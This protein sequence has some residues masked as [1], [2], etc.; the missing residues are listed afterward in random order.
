[1]EMQWENFQWVNKVE[2]F[3]ENKF[4]KYSE[5]VIHKCK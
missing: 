1:M 5:K 4:L 2:T 3:E